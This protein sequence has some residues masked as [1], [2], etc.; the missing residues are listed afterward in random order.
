MEFIFTYFLIAD[1]NQNMA[2][3]EEDDDS[4]ELVPGEVLQVT[5]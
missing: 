4:P 2:G 3:D 5:R 1:L